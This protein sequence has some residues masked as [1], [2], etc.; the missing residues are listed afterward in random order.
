MT[1]RERLS[2]QDAVG[3]DAA[4]E[5]ALFHRGQ[6]EAD[7]VRLLCKV[8]QRVIVMDVVD[9]TGMILQILVKEMLEDADGKL[10]LV[11]VED[12][13]AALV[14]DVPLD[15]EALS[16]AAGIFQRLQELLRFAG[17]WMFSSSTS[18]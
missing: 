15:R 8:D 3:D 10:A 6:Q 2:R 16:A 9:L 7:G 5:L 13:R 12:D 1:H 4:E 11:L 18:A 14:A 17:S